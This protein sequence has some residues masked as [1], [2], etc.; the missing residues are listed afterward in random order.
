MLLRVSQM[1]HRKILQADILPGFTEEKRVLVPAKIVV[2]QG[3]S[4]K[5]AVQED[6]VWT[7]PQGMS[8]GT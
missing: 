7:R 3:K 6:S 1:V 5:M 2:N 4:P 8:L